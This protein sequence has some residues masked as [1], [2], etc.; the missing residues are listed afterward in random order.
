[1]A[2]IEMDFFGHLAELRKRLMNVLW[3]LIPTVGLSFTF[4][5][6]LLTLL[7][8]PLEEAWEKR[9]MVA[10]LHYAAP[11]DAVVAYL[12]LSLGV[13]II[14]S[15]PWIFWQV[16]AFVAPGLY[17]HEKKYVLP[18]VVATAIF[19]IGGAAFGYVFVF[20]LFFEFLLDFNKGLEATMMVGEY[21]SFATRMLLA[22]GCVFEVPVVTS[23]LAL[24]GIVNWKQLLDFGRWWIVIASVLAAILTP[25][26][27]MSQVMMLIPLIV[28]YFGSVGVAYVIGPKVSASDRADDAS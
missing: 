26:D 22:F 3:G 24:L 4:R 15:A 27:P 28:L 25:P 1:E 6:E 11:I 2:D 20:P 8:A 21:V 19:F 12:K 23:L 18:F 16:W 9:G 10:K 13:G 7:K 14:L 17:R 5:E